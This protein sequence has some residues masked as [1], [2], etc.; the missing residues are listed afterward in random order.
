MPIVWRSR[1]MRA[2]EGELRSS[3][4]DPDW[5]AAGEDARVGQLL[6]AVVRALDGERKLL[7]PD[8]AAYRR[9]VERARRDECIRSEL[10]GGATTTQLAE[11]HGLSI[12]QVE[13]IRGDTIGA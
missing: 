2:L 3:I 1:Q 8:L 9:V 7:V 12:R 13:R 4:R 5:V 6:E 11:R 10:A